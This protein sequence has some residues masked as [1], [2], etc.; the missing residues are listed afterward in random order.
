MAVSVARVMKVKL[1]DQGTSHRRKKKKKKVKDCPC[2]G[3]MEAAREV[4]GGRG[5]EVEAVPS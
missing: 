3:G 1:A 2:G 5:W 4:A